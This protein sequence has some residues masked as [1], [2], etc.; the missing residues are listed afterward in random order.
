MVPPHG[1]DLLVSLSTRALEFALAD[2]G[3]HEVGGN[4]QGAAIER[5]LAKVGLAPGNPWCAAA[6]YYWFDLAAA[7]TGLVNPVPKTGSTLR[8]WALAEP[9][10]RDSNPSVGAVYVVKHSET[11]GH[12]GIIEAVTPDG[13]IEVSGNTNREGSRDGDSVWRHSGPSPEV[14][15]GGE[16]LGYLQFDRA[17]QPPGVA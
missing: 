1:E 7:R 6:L 2:V 14:I 8:L 10:C 15:H 4:N 3:V 5:Y 13:I 11:T 16:L 12:V 17:A 9:Y